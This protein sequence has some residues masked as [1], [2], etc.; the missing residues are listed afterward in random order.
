[1]I[2]SNSKF[3]GASGTASVPGYTFQGDADTGIYRSAANLFHMVTNGVE[4]MTFDA[5]G[6]V[7]I[8]TTNPGAKLDVNG[9]TKLGAAGVAVTNMGACTVATQAYTA[10]TPTNGTCTGMPAT[11]AVAVTC[12]P[13]AA[14]SAAGTILA[15]STGAGAGNQVAITLSSTVTTVAMYC[16]WIQP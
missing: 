8:G 13:G 1:M 5:T 12:S 3:Y 2:S 6:N 10:S 4:R 7:G 9:T 15:R 16:M 11:A 14:L